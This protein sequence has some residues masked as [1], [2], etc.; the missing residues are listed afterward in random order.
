MKTINTT[1]TVVKDKQRKTER[2]SA[3]D[4]LLVVIALYQKLASIYGFDFYRDDYKF[5]WR[6][7]LSFFW[8]FVC[9]V[10]CV[11]LFLHNLIIGDREELLRSICFL[12]CIIQVCFLFCF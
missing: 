2:L 3:Y 4:Q 1:M 12:A 11:Y 6:I 8:S 10:D 9:A 7:K 5:N